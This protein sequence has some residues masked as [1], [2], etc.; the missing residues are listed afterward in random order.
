MGR[1]QRQPQAYERRKHR[2]H[3]IT[4]AT[5]PRHVRVRRKTNRVRSRASRPLLS[6]ASS[7]ES[8]VTHCQRSCMSCTLRPAS[9]G[10]W[11]LRVTRV[12]RPAL[13]HRAQIS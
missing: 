1:V 5:A 13:Q 9:A 11:G 8:V 6:T 12:Q 2:F 10:C 3:V 4:N 7:Q